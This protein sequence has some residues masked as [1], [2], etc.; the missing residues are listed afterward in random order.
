MKS[1]EVPFPQAR[2]LSRRE[3]GSRLEERGAV[4]KEILDRLRTS[5]F[6]PDPYI[7]RLCLDEALTNAIVHGNRED[8]SKKVIVQLYGGDP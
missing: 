3:M 7:D 6:R 4:I 1:S 5:G 8:P 2:E